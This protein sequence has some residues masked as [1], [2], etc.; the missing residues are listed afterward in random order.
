MTAQISSFCGKTI[1]NEKDGS[2][3]NANL[4]RKYT[5]SKVHNLHKDMR[6][7]LANH[8]Y[9]SEGTAKRVYDLH[10]KSTRKMGSTTFFKILHQNRK[11]E[12]VY[13]TTAIQT[14][15]SNDVKGE[16]CLSSAFKEL[17]SAILLD[18]IRYILQSVTG[19]SC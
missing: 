13:L 12:N 17:N 19:T 7:N 5:V 11:E 14:H 18:K 1:G 3:I 16:K 8:M 10:E 6:K 15:F 2:G 9:H 4:I